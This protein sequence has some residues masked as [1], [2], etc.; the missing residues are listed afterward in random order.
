MSIHAV[1]ILI[2]L[3]TAHRRLLERLGSQTSQR[4]AFRL[5]EDT[6]MSLNDV[7]RSAH[8]WHKHRTP[9]KYSW[10]VSTT[11]TCWTVHLSTKRGQWLPAGM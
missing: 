11:A 3:M 8:R 10:H 5:A 9:N 2:L 1:C 4:Y 7:Q 6:A